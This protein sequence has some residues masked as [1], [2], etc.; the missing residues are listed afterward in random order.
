VKLYAVSSDDVCGGEVNESAGEWVCSPRIDGVCEFFLK[1]AP[2][3]VKRCA[4]ALKRY[5]AIVFPTDVNSG[6]FR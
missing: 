2:V 1:Y 6:Y 3:F 4:G 5:E